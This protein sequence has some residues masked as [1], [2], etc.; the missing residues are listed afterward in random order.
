MKKLLTILLFLLP[1]W[2][3]ADSGF[4]TD[5]P[6]F[7]QLN[8]VFYD[9]EN[10]P[11]SGHPSFDGTNL[12]VVSS[13]TLEY[14]EM[15]T[16]EHAPHDIHR[17]VLLYRFAT[18]GGFQF[19]ELS[20]V[21]SLATEGD[22]KRYASVSID[23]LDGL[24]P[25][26]TY[27][28][29]VFFL[30]EYTNWDTEFGNHELNNNQQFYILTF[31][32]PEAV[33]INL[34]NFSLSAKDDIVNVSWETAS[35][36]DN[37]YFQVEHS[38]NA[39]D[40][41]TIG[42]IDGVNQSNGIQNYSFIDKEPAYGINY[43]RLKQFDYDG[44]TTTFEAKDIYVRNGIRE[45]EIYPNPFTELIHISNNSKENSKYKIYDLKGVLLLE[46]YLEQE[47]DI[48]LESLQNGIYQII[49]FDGDQN[50]YQKRIVKI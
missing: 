48:S 17:G 45:P 35:E 41:N 21:V 12:G 6:A 34:T 5:C 9:I 47:D 8:G 33:S 44:L 10:C 43:Y 28:M 2:L 13:L 16:W 1:M 29:Q 14:G 15:Q 23:L 20:N 36:I 25:D 7:I 24:T 11:D 39:Y 26:S 31:T 27:N 30:A 32:T 37:D 4:F 49:I 22:E 3:I 40:W 38:S 50:I 19:I 42:K 18:S 46:G